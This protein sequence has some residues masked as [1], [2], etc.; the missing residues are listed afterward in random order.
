MTAMA[1][2][3]QPQFT[4]PEGPA[5]IRPEHAQ[6]WVISPVAG[7]PMAFRA[8]TWLERAFK[9]GQLSGGSKRFT[10]RQ[11]LQAGQD[12]YKLA[13]IS[14]GG[15]STD[16]TQV[17]NID[18][19]G[20]GYDMPASQDAASRLLRKIDLML[21]DNDR[22]I[23]RLVCAGGSKPVEVIRLVC[24]DYADDTG[25]RLREALDSLCSAWWRVRNARDLETVAT[26]S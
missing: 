2:K 1:R 3:K 25:S 8:R 22:T 16:S 12:Y 4:Q 23:I 26:A 10:D 24:C 20:G 6:D 9:K 17:L 18:R 5:K 21:G 15:G 11:R 13:L 7:A 19:G 14:A